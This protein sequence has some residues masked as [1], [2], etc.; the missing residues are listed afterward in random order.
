MPVPDLAKGLSKNQKRILELLEIKPEMTA[1]EIAEMLFG[2]LV[3]YKSKEY[4]SVY[5]S[6]QSLEKKGY[7][8]RVHIQLR[9]R[10]K[11]QMLK[12]LV[13]TTP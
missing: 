5:R 9:W 7:I 2:R 1:R 11:D 13:R 4:S 8:Q 12:S 3:K 10:R 6:L